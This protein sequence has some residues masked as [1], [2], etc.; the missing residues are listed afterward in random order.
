MRVKA[1]KGR[2]V[3]RSEEQV[4]RYRKESCGMKAE[5]GGSSGFKRYRS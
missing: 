5:E 3:L 1:E 4:M 2:G